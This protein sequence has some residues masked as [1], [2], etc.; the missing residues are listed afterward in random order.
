MQ[1]TIKKLETGYYVLE[2]ASGDQSRPFKTKAEIKRRYPQYEIT[3]EKD[4]K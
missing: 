3:E 1:A 2:L 4:R